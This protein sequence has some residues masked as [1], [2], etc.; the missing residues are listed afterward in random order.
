MA[1]EVKKEGPARISRRSLHSLPVEEASR[2]AVQT[3]ETP[4]PVPQN[5]HSKRT[6]TKRRLK[7][8]VTM[9]NRGVE[10]DT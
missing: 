1:A 6:A 3:G 4:E 2:G 9:Q 10:T 7:G 5:K 8:E